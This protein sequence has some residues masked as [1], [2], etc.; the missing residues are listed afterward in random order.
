MIASY[1]YLL[2]WCMCTQVKLVTFSRKLTVKSFPPR[3]IPTKCY[4][5]RMHTLYPPNNQT[6]VY[7]GLP[8]SIYSYTLRSVSAQLQWRDTFQPYR[9]GKLPNT[10]YYFSYAAE[11][12]S[13]FDDNARSNN[14]EIRQSKQQKPWPTERATCFPVDGIH[15]QREVL[16]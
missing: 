13:P 16:V 9:A 14:A 11:E 3:H 8:L 4:H 7:P 1:V 12:S 10:N 6:D 15:G 5:V 2:C